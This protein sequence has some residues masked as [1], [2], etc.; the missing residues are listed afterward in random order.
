M[1]VYWQWNSPNGKLDAITAG[2]RT[3]GR[4]LPEKLHIVLQPFHLNSP[5]DV[6]AL[7]PGTQSTDPDQN[8]V[9]GNGELYGNQKIAVTI[10]EKNDD[11]TTTE[12]VSIVSLWYSHPARHSF[13]KVVFMP[14]L[15]TPAG[16]Y[17]LWRGSCR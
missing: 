2:G 12:M 3:H 7:R 10:A 1:G 11:K 15:P 16:C 6:G 4:S 13:E 5:I 14:G 9:E 17:N 8:G